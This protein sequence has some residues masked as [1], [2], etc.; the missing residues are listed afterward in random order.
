MGLNI[1]L[2]HG[3]Q[4]VINGAV[5]K[6]RSPRSTISVEN[7]AHVIR[8]PDILKPEDVD[9]PVKSVYF[10]TQLMLIDPARA[11]EH[12]LHF[13]TYMADVLAA[14]RSGADTDDLQAAIGFVNDG[15]YYRALVAIRMV[16]QRET[17]RRL[18]GRS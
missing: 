1:R 5:I 17:D 16:L 13:N 2:Q 9:T 14:S 7:Y 4:C 10:A 8:A 12:R 18:A 11:D 15:D 3:D 6:C